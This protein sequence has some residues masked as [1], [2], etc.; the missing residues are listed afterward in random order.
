MSFVRTEASALIPGHGAGW[1]I[2]ARRLLHKFSAHLKRKYFE[3]TVILKEITPFWA[4]MNQKISFFIHFPF[5][6]RVQ[7]SNLQCEL[8]ILNCLFRNRSFN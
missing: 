6:F 7:L 1:M 8:H 3:N 4:I 2:V 5:K